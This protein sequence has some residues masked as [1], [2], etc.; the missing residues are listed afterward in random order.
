MIDKIAIDMTRAI[1]FPVHLGFIAELLTGL[2]SVFVVNGVLNL[3]KGLL[4]TIFEV[5][6]KCVVV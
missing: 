2:G 3:L 5:L 6:F 4:G 1:T